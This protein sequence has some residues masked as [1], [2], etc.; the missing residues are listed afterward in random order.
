MSQL[1][2]ELLTNAGYFVAGFFTYFLRRR[3]INYRKSS[4]RNIR[5][6]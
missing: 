3:V 6:S 1:S 2:N 5:K 4:K